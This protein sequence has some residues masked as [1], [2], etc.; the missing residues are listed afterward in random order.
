V[1]HTKYQMN[2]EET[3][4]KFQVWV[5]SPRI[6]RFHKSRPKRSKSSLDISKVMFHNVHGYLLDSK[7]LVDTAVVRPRIYHIV[8][9]VKPSILPHSWICPFFVNSSRTASYG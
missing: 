2:R 1:D 6:E 7:L 5:R 8:N 9:N 3:L 4:S